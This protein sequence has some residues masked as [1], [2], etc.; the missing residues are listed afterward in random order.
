MPN[1]RKMNDIELG[2]REREKGRARTEKIILNQNNETEYMV[3][4]RLLKFFVM[5]G[6]K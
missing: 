1:K 2:Y 6:I 5:L 3:H 4:Y